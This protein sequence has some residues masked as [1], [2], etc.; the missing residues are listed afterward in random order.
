MTKL[1]GK[2]IETHEKSLVERKV[3]LMHGT[4]P[5]REL[6]FLIS[7]MDGLRGRKFGDRLARAVI[8]QYETASKVGRDSFRGS[9]TVQEVEKVLTSDT[10]RDTEEY[11]QQMLPVVAIGGID[12]RKVKGAK[13]FPMAEFMND[14]F[15]GRFES[16]AKSPVLSGV[17]G[18]VYGEALKIGL[19]TAEEIKSRGL[20]NS[21]YAPHMRGWMIWAMAEGIVRSGGKRIRLI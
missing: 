15:Q 3:G 11:V 2:I 19:R 9:V 17:E 5:Y 6:G 1:S 20:N 21:Y 10:R 16:A 12:L 8:E 18:K 14:F 4:A 7:A 13:M